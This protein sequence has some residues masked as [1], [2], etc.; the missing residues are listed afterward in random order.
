MVLIVG[1]QE[2]PPVAGIYLCITAV[3]FT[4]SLQQCSP[5]A[6]SLPELPSRLRAFA[7]SG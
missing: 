5:Q 3:F 7:L 6:N 1:G 2:P 4:G